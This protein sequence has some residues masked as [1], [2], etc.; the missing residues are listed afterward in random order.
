MQ[1]N[2]FDDYH[3]PLDQRPA[4]PFKKYKPKGDKSSIYVYEF[5][6]KNGKYRHEYLEKGPNG[7]TIVSILHYPEKVGEILKFDAND[8]LIERD[9]KPVQQ[10][11]TSPFNP[12]EQPA[13]VDILKNRK[14]YEPTYIFTYRDDNG[15]ITRREFL[16]VH[17]DL[18]NTVR[19]QFLDIGWVE[20]NY[21]KNG[22][23]TNEQQVAQE[24]LKLGLIERT[25]NEP[26]DEK[27]ENAPV[28]EPKKEPTSGIMHINQ[29][30]KNE[31]PLKPHDQPPVE[32]YSTA[33][34]NRRPLPLR[35]F[36]RFDK[37]VESLIERFI[38]VSKKREESVKND[39]GQITSLNVYTDKTD[40]PKEKYTYQYDDRGR[41]I[42]M[43]QHFATL[44]DKE[45]KLRAKYAYTYR[46]NG[47]WIE[48]I[49]E[50]N[51][52]GT[53]GKR[54]A[55][56]FDKDGTR[57]GEIPVESVAELAKPVPQFDP[58]AVRN[59]IPTE[60]FVYFK[61]GLFHV[62]ERA[63]PWAMRATPQIKTKT[64]DA[65][66]QSDKGNLKTDPTLLYKDG[67][68]DTI[69]KHMGKNSRAQRATPESANK[70]ETK[71]TSKKN[72]IKYHV[73]YGGRK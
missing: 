17:K 5:K 62:G 45:P 47:D 18:T 43:E 49:Q 73:N 7:V 26:T 31:Q 6:T 48:E 28:P 57:L 69:T 8:V 9:G 72:E 68:T 63:A 50:I 12:G 42:S 67:D 44:L 40:M 61:D 33:P 37:G 22:N 71:G 60:Q 35:L 27:T 20:Y 4:K 64:S 1:Y 16:D 29:N 23:L 19:I 70:P 46:S 25:A 53:P 14:G 36:E 65:T 56:F 66:S 34:A 55:W 2:Q 39:Q 59:E 21:D 15:F 38:G 30:Q 11:Y 3:S 10:Q 13:E 51:K 54:T 52:D 41:L 32:I 58:T 24:L